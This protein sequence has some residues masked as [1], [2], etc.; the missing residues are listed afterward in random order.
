M[1][2]IAT[3]D[4]HWHLTGHGLTDQQA[5]Y[6]ISEALRQGSEASDYRRMVATAKLYNL[7]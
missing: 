5:D 3:A 7:L 1:S 4:A 6:V 2:S